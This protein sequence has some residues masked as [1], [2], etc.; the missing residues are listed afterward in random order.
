[1]STENNNRALVM[2][3][4]RRLLNGLQS[5]IFPHNKSRCML[6]QI[7]NQIP[8]GFVIDTM[9]TDIVWKQQ[10]TLQIIGACLIEEAK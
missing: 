6:T 5:W 7:Q 1:M 9:L 2:T 4:T 3:T 8:P 10:M